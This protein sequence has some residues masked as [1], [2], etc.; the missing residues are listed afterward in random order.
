MAEWSCIL[1]IGWQNDWH[2]KLTCSVLFSVLP[3]DLAKTPAALERQGQVDATSS[4]GD[5]AIKSSDNNSVDGT[6]VAGSEESTVASVSSDIGIP[7][8]VIKQEPLEEYENAQ[9]EEPEVWMPS[10]S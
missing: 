3:A 1:L 6:P 8:L 9:F 2:I 10:C 7:L 4:S 5:W